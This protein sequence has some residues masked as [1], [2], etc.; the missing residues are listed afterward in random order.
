MAGANYLCAVTAISI[1]KSK[2]MQPQQKPVVQA[3]LLNR[4]KNSIPSHMLSNNGLCLCIAA[5]YVLLLL[6][7]VV[8]STR[9]GISRSYTLLL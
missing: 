4:T 9:F 3:K 1:T 7:L 5:H 8:N 6:V 2:S